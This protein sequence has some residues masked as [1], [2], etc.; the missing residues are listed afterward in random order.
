MHRFASEFFLS[1]FVLPDTFHL[2]FDHLHVSIAN[3]VVVGSMSTILNDYSSQPM[4]MINW[5]YMQVTRK[6]LNLLLTPFLYSMSIMLVNSSLCFSFF[7]RL[8]LQ[9]I[10][11]LT[12]SFE[13]THLFIVQHSIIFMCL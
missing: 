2:D 11:K 9:A 1:G 7:I 13:N 4:N 5:R 12:I 3:P 6:L 10:F 8:C